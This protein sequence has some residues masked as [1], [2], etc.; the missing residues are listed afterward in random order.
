MIRNEQ[1]SPFGSGWTL[2]G[3]DRL[4]PTTGDTLLLASG[5]GRTIPFVNT[6]VANFVSWWPAEGSAQDLRSGF[7][8][9][10]QNGVTFAT[11][12]VGQAFN[13][14][15]VNDF[16]SVSHNVAHNPPV[17]TMAGWVNITQAPA[18]GQEYYVI[19]KYGGNFDGYIL[20]VGSTMFPTFSLLRTPNVASHITSASPLPLNTWVHLAATY[21]GATLSIYLN[22]ALQG[23]TG[24][25]GGYTGATVPLAIGAAS[26]FSGGFTKGVMD[27]VELYS[28]ALSASQVNALYSS[29]GRKDLAADFSAPPSEYSLLK[30]N[31]DGTYTRTLKDGTTYQFSAQG[32]QTSLADRNGNTTTYAYNGTNQLT[33]L[34]DPPAR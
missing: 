8:G 2:R 25:T 21:D 16:I 5:E 14:D 18:T 32:L 6:S 10:L 7:N 27:G 17:L 24:L 29:G 26:W 34:T 13:L 11:G 20:R 9:T 4:I 1:H 28:R 30:R 15:G 23:S 19:S 31:L 33:T 22:G 3:V 12:Q